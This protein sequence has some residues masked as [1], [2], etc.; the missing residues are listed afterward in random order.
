MNMNISKE[1]VDFLRNQVNLNIAIPCYGG[2]VHESV[3]TSL[4]R[5]MSHAQ[6]LG[7]KCEV[8]TLS[9]ESLIS[10]GRNSEV[11]KALENKGVTHL[12]FI[13][14]D[15]G[16]APEHIFKL[17]LAD[18]DI[19]GGLYPKK[20]L[21]PDFV[22]NVSPSAVDK[23]GKLIH[24][25]DGLI[26]VSR[27]GTGFMLIKRTVFEQMMVA[28]PNTKYTN[29]IGLDP[30]YDP[31][32]YTFFDSWISQDERREYLSEDWGFCEKARAIG[33][34]C[35]ADPTVRLNHAGNFIFPGN[36]STLQTLYNQMG[37]DIKSNPKLTPRVAM[38]QDSIE[39]GTTAMTLK[40]DLE[41]LAKWKE[42]QISKP[43]ILEQMPNRLEISSIK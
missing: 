36:P 16:F 6:S 18:K 2:M 31:Y 15:I 11:S 35:Y 26:P 22:V 37:I 8:Q 4:I 25:D 17:L 32:M 33:I 27:L 43:I 24:R 34:Q 42:E 9:N 23:D 41:A 29:N 14:A 12:L 19:I 13:D 1:Q 20:S 7:M 3:M 5:F 21:P 38:R 39:D 40:P 28:Y 30:K 10:R